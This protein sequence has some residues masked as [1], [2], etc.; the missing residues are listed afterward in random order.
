V[1]EYVRVFA[2]LDVNPVTG[3]TKLGVAVDESA[4]PVS[5]DPSAMYPPAVTFPA[6][7]T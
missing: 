4:M 6:T 7:F 2:T 3:G 1:F 5:N